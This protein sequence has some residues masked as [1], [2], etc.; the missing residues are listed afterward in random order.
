MKRL[1]V[2]KHK[3]TNRPVKGLFFTK[4]MDAK[5]ERDRLNKEADS[6]EYVVS[7]GPDHYKMKEE[8]G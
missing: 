3:P 6:H 8:E 2:V 5:A 1:F 7:Y 4:K